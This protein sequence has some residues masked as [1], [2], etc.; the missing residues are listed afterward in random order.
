MINKII[1]YLIAIASLIFMFNISNYLMLLNTQNYQYFLLQGQTEYNDVI[2]M[3]NSRWQL[4]EFMNLIL[5]LF[6]VVVIGLTV[7]KLFRKGVK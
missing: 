5:F 7:I 3:F 2:Q 4:L 6:I 1:K